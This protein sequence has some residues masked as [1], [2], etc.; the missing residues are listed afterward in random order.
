[1]KGGVS[2]TN[3]WGLPLMPTWKHADVFPI[4]ADIIRDSYAQEPRYITHDEITSQLLADPAAV[5]IIADAH[6]QE[7]DRSPEWLA[8][9][10]VAWFSQRITSGDSDWD[11]AFDRREID[12]KW[13][14][15]PKEG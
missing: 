14:Y 8:H 4:I 13:A 15:K 9:N 10:M 6:D 2:M 7:S 11:H 12:G 5:G 1:M 3:D